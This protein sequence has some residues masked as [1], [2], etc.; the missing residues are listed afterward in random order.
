MISWS[1]IETALDT[2]NHKNPALF[3]RS[4]PIGGWAAL[5]YHR[6][7]AFKKDL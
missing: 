4:L 3:S 2:L 1:T 6:L 5:L 7:L